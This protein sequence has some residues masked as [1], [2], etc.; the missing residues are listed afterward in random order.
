MV[1]DGSLLPNRLQ[2]HQ[3]YTV[4]DASDTYLKAAEQANIDH[5]LE[6]NWHKLLLLKAIRHFKKQ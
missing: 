4:Q 1:S 2:Y 5:M 3:L 6:F